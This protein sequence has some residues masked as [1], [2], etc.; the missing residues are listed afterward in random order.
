MNLH[1]FAPVDTYHSMEQWYFAVDNKI[2]TM[3]MENW[4]N[5]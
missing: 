2:K 1:T 4:K 5:L 3:F